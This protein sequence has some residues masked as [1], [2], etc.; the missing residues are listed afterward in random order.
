MKEL[1]S[2]IKEI[3]EEKTKVIISQRYEDAALLRDR[4]RILLR[5]LSKNKYFVEQYNIYLENKKEEF[6]NFLLVKDGF[7]SVQFFNYA[8]EQIKQE[9]SLP[10]AMRIYEEFLEMQKKS[11]I[12][13]HIENKED[14][15]FL[16]K[17]II[18]NII[19]FEKWFSIQNY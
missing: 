19:N 17:W 4:E 5:E 8:L 12:Q 16:N 2:K 3:R 14:T 7:Y 9:S 6:E 18:S 10:T 15:Q 13:Y 1:I 11:T